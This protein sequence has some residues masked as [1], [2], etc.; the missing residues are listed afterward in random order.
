[1]DDGNAPRRLP[2]SH[3]VSLVRLSKVK[4]ETQG[5]GARQS[6]NGKRRRGVQC[7]L[8]LPWVYSVDW[9][10]FMTPHPVQANHQGQRDLGSS[11][12]TLHSRARPKQHQAQPLSASSLAPATSSDNLAV[13]PFRLCL[14]LAPAP[15]S[16]LFVLHRPGLPR[17]ATQRS[18]HRHCDRPLC[19]LLCTS[20]LL[21]RHVEYVY[22]VLNACKP[23]TTSRQCECTCNEHSVVASNTR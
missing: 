18:R 12:R 2:S 10:A 13:F 17:L 23:T 16:V 9:R 8:M 6:G 19:L 5:R 14:R 22:T 3:R 11:L 7:A 4:Q 21:S 15:G 20:R 1:M